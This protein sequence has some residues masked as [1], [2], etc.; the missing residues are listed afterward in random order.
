MTHAHDAG[1]GNAPH[2]PFDRLNDFVDGVLP[3]AERDA[4]ERHVA[5]CAECRHDVD[6]LRRLLAAVASVPRAVEPPPEVWAAVRGRMAEREAAPLVRRTWWRRAPALG[7]AAGLLAAASVAF[8]V[9]RARPEVPSDGAMPAS[10]RPQRPQMDSIITA[11]IAFAEKTLADPAYRPTSQMPA[12][13]VLGS[14]RLAEIADAARGR[15]DEWHVTQ[16]RGWPEGRW[17]ACHPSR[18]CVDVVLPAARQ[19]A[20]ADRAARELTTTIRG[21]AGGDAAGL[22]PAARASLDRNLAVVESAIAEARA[23]L[24]RDPEN[25]AVADALG[26]AQE[27]RVGLLQQAARLLSD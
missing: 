10:M 9:L 22:P 12:R 13:T 14:T 19:L 17:L 25:R 18:G 27:R 8:T 5:A 11:V 1:G 23:A 15:G 16:D 21:D 2:P 6:G 20:A 7:A 24:A 26:A 4:V 3:A